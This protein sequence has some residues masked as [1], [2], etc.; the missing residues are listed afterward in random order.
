MALMKTLAI[1]KASSSASQFPG[2]AVEGFIDTQVAA[3]TLTKSSGG[4]LGW[5]AAL[6]KASRGA[7]GS[8]RL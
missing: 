7:L 5:G 4:V 1:T 2:C 8:G 3:S 6:T